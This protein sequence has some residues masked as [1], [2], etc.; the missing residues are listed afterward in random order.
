VSAVNG[1]VGEAFALIVELCMALGHENIST[2]PGLLR[3]D[4]DANWSVAV[5]GHKAIVDLVPGYHVAISY[6]GFPAGLLNPSDGMIVAG[7][8]ANEDALIAALRARLAE[9]QS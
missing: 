1:G 2:L 4:I 3:V 5:N 8:A 7:E 9:V 6:N